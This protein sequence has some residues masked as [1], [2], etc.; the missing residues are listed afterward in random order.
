MESL[1]MTIPYIVTTICKAEHVGIF[2]YFKDFEE[3]IEATDLAKVKE[4]MTLAN[5]NV[6]ILCSLMFVVMSAY[7]V[8]VIFLGPKIIAEYSDIT[9]IRIKMMNAARKD[10]EHKMN[11][12]LIRE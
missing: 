12:R 9:T 6:Y 3:V 2:Q 4:F 1:G 10:I 8:S 7:L 11:T 5:N